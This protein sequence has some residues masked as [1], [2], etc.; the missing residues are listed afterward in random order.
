MSPTDIREAP[1]YTMT[2]EEAQDCFKVLDALLLTYAEEKLGDISNMFTLAQRH[3]LLWKLY[4][5]GKIEVVTFS[6]DRDAIDIRHVPFW[7]WKQR[8]R[9]RANAKWLV[10]IYQAQEI[11]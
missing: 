4:E 3:Q 9:C 8:R 6:N 7:C 11:K 5:Q 2:Y 10:E 1:N